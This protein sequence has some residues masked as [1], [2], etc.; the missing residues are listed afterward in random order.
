MLQG[1]GS[2]FLLSLLL[3]VFSVGFLGVIKLIACLALLLSGAVIV[4]Y[5][6]SE[7]KPSETSGG[8]GGEI[9]TEER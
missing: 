4:A 6:I 7:E 5:A 1:T 9:K 2:W 3:A 8:G